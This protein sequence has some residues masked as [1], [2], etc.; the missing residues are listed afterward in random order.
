MRWPAHAFFF[1]FREKLI[2]TRFY[3]SLVPLLT[4]HLLPRQCDTMIC[5]GV[6]SMQDSIAAR[7]QFM[8]ALAIKDILQV[9]KKEEGGREGTNDSLVCLWSVEEGK[10]VD[11]RSS[12]DPFGQGSLCTLR[13]R[14]DPERRRVQTIDYDADLV[15]YAA[16]CQ[17]PI[18]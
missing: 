4:D 8:L 10:I 12:D 17:S 2:E 14:S 1:F 15:L 6:G 3:E 11:L 5:Y 7:Y 16:L 9:R 18:Q 13:P